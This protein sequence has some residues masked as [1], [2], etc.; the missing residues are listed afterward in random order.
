LAANERKKTQI[1][2]VVSI[3]AGVWAVNVQQKPSL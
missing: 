1:N 2:L 3:V